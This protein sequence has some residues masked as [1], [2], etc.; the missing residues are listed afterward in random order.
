MSLFL[1]TNYGDSALNY[2]AKQWGVGA[3]S[4][5]PDHLNHGDSALNYQK[6]PHIGHETVELVMM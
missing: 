5:Y 6:R 3:R 2:Y 1:I 4:G